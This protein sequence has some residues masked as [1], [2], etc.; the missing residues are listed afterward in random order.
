MNCP[1]CQHENTDNAKFCEKCAAPLPRICVACGGRVSLT[2]KFCAECGHRLETVT[3]DV[4]FSSPKSYTPQ[5][6]AD[7]ILTSRAALEGERKQ[8]TVLFADIKG[9]MEVLAGRDPEDAQKLL[10]PVLERMIEAVHRYEGTV[11]RVMGD[12]VMALFGAPIAHEDH[13]VRACHAAMRMQESVARYADEIQRSQGIPVAIRVGVNSGEI[14]VWGIGNDLYMDYTVVGQTAHLAARMEQMAKPGSVL[15]TADTFRLV[16]GYVAMKPL[17]DVPIKGLADPVAVY[18]VTGAGAARTRLQ[19]AARHGWT[20]FVGRD[21]E[22]EQL[23]RVQQLAGEGRAQ[24]VAI[25]GEAGVGK[26]RLLHEFAHSHYA[27]DWLILESNCASYGHT[28]PYLPVIELLRHYFQINRDDVTLSIREKVTA[29]V[30]R[31]DASLQDAAAPVLDLLDALHDEDPFRSLDPLERQRQTYQAVTRLLLGET[32]ARP[33]LAIFEDLHWNDPLT[34]GLLNEL[35]V[36]AKDVRLLVVVSYRPELR[37][38]WGNRPNYCQLRLDPLASESVS[39]F[40]EALLGSDPSLL[41][42]KNFLVDRASGNPFFVEEIVRALVD[43]GVLEGT[44]G[45]YQ[46]ARPFSS[47]EVPPTVHAVLAARIDAL[48]AAGKRL[49]HEAA[50]IGHDVPFSLLRAICDLTEDELR[51]LLDNLQAAEFLYATQLFPDPQYTFKHALTHDVTY[52]GVL[53][54]RRRDIH[55]RVVDAMERLYADRVGEQAERLAHHAVRGELKEKAVHYLRQAGEKAAARAALSDARASFEQALGILKALPESQPALEQAFEIRL[56]LRPVLRQLGE[57]WQMLEH[58]REAQ[59]LAERLKDERRGGRVCTFM[60][61]V[62]S[63]LNELDEALATGTRALEIARRLGDLQLRIVSTGHLE[64]AHYYRGE[65]EHVI[66]LGTENLAALPADWAHEYFGTAVLPSVFARVWLIMSLGELGRFGEAAKY[67]AE[68]IQLAEPMQHA[69]TTGW[70]HVGASMLHLFKGDWAKAHS[71]IEQWINIPG[72]LDVA[73]LLPWAVASSAWALAEIGEASEALSRVREGEQLLER[74]AARGIVA[75]RGWA[76]HAAGQACL[77]LGRLDEARRLGQRS[78]ESSQRQPGFAAYAQRLLGDIAS[79]PARFDA[80]S[81]A[82]HYRGAKKIAERHGMRPLVA[83]CHLGLGKLYRR[84]GQL[85]HARNN[86]G[87]A[88]T[89]YRDMDMA[90]FLRE[91]D[92]TRH[93]EVKPGLRARQKSSASARSKSR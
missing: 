10:D 46:L 1:K 25:V 35:V 16:E 37:D 68:A 22:L 15:T 11:N 44:R 6:L 20:Q 60:T 88:A 65:Y 80:E 64:Q 43:T 50:V 57:G 62:L 2:A 81:S 53:H 32:R 48:P 89:M 24:V 13:A 36:A 55:A 84:T 23:R 90:F 12:G 49:L 18:E 58:L 73:V 19:A 30:L 71:L 78:V 9:S 54:E 83:H 40:L 79:H 34:L 86:L 5:H 26:S 45:S 7:K 70:A 63:T 67:E 91:A 47:I 66:E 52:S 14:V 76:Y 4:R 85:E 72:T 42:L 51:G 61:T 39:A 56:E 8:V 59:V 75:H 87:I 93:D 82:A 29:K 31:L 77:L 3:E 33:V 92:A 17:G 21:I 41:A 38:E 74:Q 28:T 27:E 69:H